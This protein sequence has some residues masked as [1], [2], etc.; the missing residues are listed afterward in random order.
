LIL[1]KDGKL[2]ASA[3]TTSCVPGQWPQFKLPSM[4]SLTFRRPTARNSA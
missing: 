2:E 3:L 1:S 4:H